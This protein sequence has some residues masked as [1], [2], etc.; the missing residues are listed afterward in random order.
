MSDHG[1]DDARL[2]GDY[3]TIFVLIVV[4]VLLLVECRVRWI[5]RSWLRVGADARIDVEKCAEVEDWDDNCSSVDGLSD[6]DITRKAHNEGWLCSHFPAGEELNKR[7]SSIASHKRLGLGMRVDGKLA[8]TRAKNKRRI[9]AKRPIAKNP[10]NHWHKRNANYRQAYT[11]EAILYWIIAHVRH[12]DDPG[13]CGGVRAR[14][15]S[16]RP[17]SLLQAVGGP[18]GPD[19][20]ARAEEGG[21]DCDTMIA[22]QRAV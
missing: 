18:D 4:V 21:G 17:S 7:P 5:P 22:W 14:P 2:V 10:F 6:V 3:L 15:G 12:K 11:Y 20:E 13:H 1:R 8:Q 19:G 9:T 16:G